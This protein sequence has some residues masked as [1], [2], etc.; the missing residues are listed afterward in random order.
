VGDFGVATGG[1]IWVAAG[2]GDTEFRETRRLRLPENSKDFAVERTRVK[3]CKNNSGD[4][5]D[6]RS[7][8]RKPLKY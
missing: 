1:G 6:F 4:P 7:F 5:E 2:D 8:D 3:F